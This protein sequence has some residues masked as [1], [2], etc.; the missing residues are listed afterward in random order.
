M[1]RRDQH[2]DAQPQPL[3]AGRGV[4]QQFQRRQQRRLP[5]DLFEHPAALEPELLGPGQVVALTGRVEAGG[6]ELVD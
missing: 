2:G 1:Q 5:D 3:G 6:I 4:G